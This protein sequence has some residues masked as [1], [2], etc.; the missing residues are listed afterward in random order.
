MKLKTV[1]LPSLAAVILAISF[2]IQISPAEIAPRR[3]EVVAKR[4]SF[5]P[6]EITLKKGEPVILV[7]KSVDVPH[8][9]RFKEL[10]IETKAGKGQTGELAFT[11]D[12]AGTF[13]SHCSVFCGSGHGTM[14]LTLHVVD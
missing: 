6:A 2:A 10:G 5:T 4:F 3:I 12:T 1:Q 11:P 13:V 9:I 8:G 14:E 7:L